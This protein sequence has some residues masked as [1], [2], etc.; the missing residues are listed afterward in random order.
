[1]AKGKWGGAHTEEINLTKTLP[2][3]L[4]GE[5]ITKEA[6]KEMYNLEFLLW[7]KSTGEIHVSLNP[8]KKKEICKFI[9]LVE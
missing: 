2:K 9:G 1:M 3:H 8:R 5:K 6:I 7:K 4:R